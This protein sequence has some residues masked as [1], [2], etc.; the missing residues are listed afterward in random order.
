M[1]QSA[2]QIAQNATFQSFINSYIREIDGGVWFEME[3]WLNENRTSTLLT[4]DEMVELELPHQSV[5]VA[6]EVKYRSLVGRQQFGVLL[7]YCRDRQKWYKEDH[8]TFLITLIQELHLMSKSTC[9]TEYASHYDEL[10]LRLI[11]SYQTMTNYIEKRMND[12]IAPPFNGMKFIAAEQSLHFGHWLHP[13]PKSRQGMAQW[14]HNSFAP[15]LE[16]SFQLH[17]FQVNHKLIKESSILQE[18]ASEIIKNSVSNWKCSPSI[19]EDTCIIPIHPLQTQWL[20]QQDY[21]RKAMDEGLIVNLGAHGP[22]YTATSSLRTVYNAEEAYMYKFSIPVKLTNSLRV[23]KRHELEAG[24]VMASLISKISFLEK[25]P[26]FHII[27]DP[28]YITV[29]FPNQVESGFEV[30]VRSNTF[31]KGRDLGISLIAAIVQDPM[32]NRSSHLTHLITELAYEECRSIEKVSID[33]FKKY[34]NCA[35]EPL[36]RLYDEYG[37]A[38]E[39]HQQNSV[40]DISKGYP[41]G[42]Y[43][44]D[45]QGYYLSNYYSK[46]L[47]DIEP[48]LSK[49]PELFYD[50]CLIQERFTYYLF[51]NQLFSVIYRFGADGLISE[52]K[53][54]HWVINELKL[55]ERQLTGQGK[56]FVQSI[57]LKEKLAFKANLLTRFHDVDELMAKLE[58]AVYTEIANPFILHKKEEEH[59]QA[60]SVSL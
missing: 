59:E 20:L 35:I 48:S 31:P 37:I 51:M 42:Y 10:I 28:A 46:K 58:Q 57:L 44:R 53:L 14:Q 15:E 18:S 40:L 30:I 13:T 49:T 22:N 19:S 43:Y 45:N 7:K 54:I 9:D 26:S 12:L 50:D 21:V 29:D 23:T 1:D 60:I 5:R 6:I 16:G 33:W 4:G 3:Q 27:D 56:T 36:I 17:Y 24:I 34:W 38:L 25:Y 11:E 39:A 47:R 8:L 52:N 32:P 2:K 41:E 55:L